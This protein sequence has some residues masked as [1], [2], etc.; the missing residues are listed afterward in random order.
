MVV[1]HHLEIWDF[2]LLRDTLSRASE[3]SELNSG[4]RNPEVSW[5]TDTFL[6]G[7]VVNDLVECTLSNVFMKIFARRISHEG[8][9][10]F[11]E[12]FAVPF[13]KVL[14][15]SEVVISSEG[16]IETLEKSI[17][18]NIKVDS[19]VTASAVCSVGAGLAHR[20][21][22]DINIGDLLHTTFREV[23]LVGAAFC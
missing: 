7:V 23:N 17:I 10:P 15:Q 4:Y 9:I 14:V 19:W 21:I 16:D 3:V 11:R 12:P 1:E 2:G 8:L 22:L 13:V 18:L 20:D 5:C 6:P